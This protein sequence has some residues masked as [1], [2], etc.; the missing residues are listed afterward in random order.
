MNL[1]AE[2]SQLIDQLEPIARPGGQ[3]RALMVMGSRPGAGASTVARE[4]A[5]LAALRSQRGVWLYDL[6]FAANAQSRAA[7]VQGPA[8]DAALGRDPFWAL[9]TGTGRARIVA[10]QSVVANLFVTELQTEPGALQ[11]VALRAAPDYWTAVRQ[12]IDL[13]IIDAPSQSTAPLNL[14]ADLDGVILVADARDPNGAGLLARR[15][16]IEARGGVVAGLILNRTEPIQ[17]AA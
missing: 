16:A 15:A 1:T 8:F 6:D 12:S 10:R 5:R 14:A 13:A 7:R 3:G 2:L 11:G 9:Q 17:S 4:L